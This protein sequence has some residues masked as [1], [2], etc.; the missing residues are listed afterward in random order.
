MHVEW[1]LGQAGGL[2]EGPKPGGRAGIQ[3]GWAN[4][5]RQGFPWSCPGTDDSQPPPLALGDK[6][7]RTRMPKEGPLEAVFIEGCVWAISPWRQQPWVT[8]WAVGGKVT[9]HILIRPF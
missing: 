8:E 1:G 3:P 4:S 6:S 2:R 5:S 7:F 9:R